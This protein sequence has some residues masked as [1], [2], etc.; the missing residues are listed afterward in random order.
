MC[1]K[2]FVQRNSMTSSKKFTLDFFKIAEN[3]WFIL[4]CT[5]NKQKNY[6]TGKEELT[7]CPTIKEVVFGTRND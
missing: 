3:I 2:P 5:N 1:L 4:F 7:N 6:E